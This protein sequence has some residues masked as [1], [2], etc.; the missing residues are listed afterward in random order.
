[1]TSSRLL[2]HGHPQSDATEQGQ[3]LRVV[4]D[5]GSS[6]PALPMASHMEAQRDDLNTFLDAL[7]DLSATGWLSFGR[8]VSRNAEAAE[9]RQ[10][11]RIALESIL[12]DRGLAISSWAV[13]D[14]IETAQF[15]AMGRRGGWSAEQLRAFAI[16]QHAA[17]CAALALLSRDHLDSDMFNALAGALIRT[18]GLGSGVIH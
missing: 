15:F 13:R 16:A 1:M 8:E 10:R 3:H 9:K 17:E 12:I 6:S 7:A 4:T 11:A 2:R 14:A 18:S 5:G